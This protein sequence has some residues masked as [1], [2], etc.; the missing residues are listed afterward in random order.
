M[1]KERGREKGEYKPKVLHELLLTQ[2]KNKTI[3]EKSIQNY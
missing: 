2:C 1:K 3:R